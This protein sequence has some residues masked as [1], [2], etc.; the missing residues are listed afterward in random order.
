[1]SD[2]IICWEGVP[3]SELSREELEDAL[4]TMHHMQEQTMMESAARQS[5]V[6]RLKIDRMGR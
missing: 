5:I 2:A 3:I 1:M 4:K 6:T